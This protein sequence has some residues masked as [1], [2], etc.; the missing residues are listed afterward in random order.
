MP[1]VLRYNLSLTV[2]LTLI[3]PIDLGNNN[4]AGTFTVDWGDGNTTVGSITHTYVSQNVYDVQIAATRITHFGVESPDSSTAECLTAVLSWGDIQLT[5]LSYAFFTAYNLTSVPSTLPTDINGSA[6]ITQFSNAFEYCVVFN[7]AAVTTWNVESVVDMSRMFY[8]CLVFNQ[9]LNSWSVGNVLDMNNMFAS[10]IAFN[11]PLNS[12]DVGKVTSMSAMFVSCTAFNQPLNSWDVG[13]VTSMSAMFEECPAFNQPLNSWNV[14]DVTAM[15]NMFYA[16]SS[17]N[18]PLYSWNVSKVTNMTEMFYK[19][20]VFN[21][22]LSSW[23]V[24]L[25]ENMKRMF[26][27]TSLSTFNYSQILIGWSLLSTLDVNN[28]L[29]A[30]NSFY[31]S[32]AQ[33]Y[34][35]MLTV[36]ND[37]IIHDLGPVQQSVSFTYGNTSS[38]HFTQYELIEL[39]PVQ[40]QP[41][42]ARFTNFT[43]SPNLPAQLHLNPVTGVLRGRVSDVLNRSFSIT[44]TLAVGVL[45]TKTKTKTVHLTTPPQVSILLNLEITC[46]QPFTPCPSKVFNK[47]NSS[48]S[49]NSNITTVQNTNAFRYSWLVS[50]RTRNNGRNIYLDAVTN[51][52]GGAPPRNT[53]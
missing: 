37:W 21:Q 16:C 36:T 5:D 3:L 50:N 6:Q 30:R 45:A 29:T 35:T 44:G 1:M 15:I 43:V 13:K 4:V 32:Y 53:F 49:G 17:F 48:F 28:E 24:F 18:Q 23:N 7:S 2:G 52:G 20:T 46:L 27:S 10:C 9:P 42:E 12:W 14:S 34:R 40:E 41:T 26:D 38:F 33:P 11:Q 19:C 22:D 39:I 31:Y 51:N 8:N 25:V 47:P